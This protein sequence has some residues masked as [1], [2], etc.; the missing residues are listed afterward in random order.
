M[1][2]IVSREAAAD[3]ERLYFFLAKGDPKAADRAAATLEDAI[4]SLDTMPGRG[5]PS[6]LPNTRELIVPFGR[7][8]YV[9]RYSIENKEVV[10]FRVWHG[11]ETRV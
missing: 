11:R 4:Q 2:L 5:R 10:V 7:S 1:S 3:L 9:L 6:K 8:A